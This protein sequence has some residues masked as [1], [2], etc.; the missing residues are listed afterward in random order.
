MV[1]LPIFV[2][3]QSFNIH[4]DEIKQYYGSLK[5]EIDKLQ[6]RLTNQIKSLQGKVNTSEQT[7]A[8][9]TELS[10]RYR[11]NDDVIKR[12]FLYSVVVLIYT[13]I[14]ERLN[15]IQDFLYFSKNKRAR[16]KSSSQENWNV[17]KKLE[18]RFSVS[19][20]AKD[21]KFIEDTAL[22]RNVIAHANGDLSKITKGRYG[23]IRKISSTPIGLSI[24]E[25]DVLQISD[26]YISY[27]VEETRN[28]FKNIYEKLKKHFDRRL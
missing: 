21:K 15:R 20:D 23:K 25:H 12:F 1:N 11:L 14:E 2:N 27:L 18:K 24:D 19:I 13:L 17:L 16:S 8:I 26:D 9:Y 7:D 3:E 5:S 4:L 28:V 6:N 22:I 10:E